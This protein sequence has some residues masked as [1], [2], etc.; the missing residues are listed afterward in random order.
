MFIW[1]MISCLI[2]I[3]RNT[4]LL[5]THRHGFWELLHFN[6]NLFQGLQRDNIATLLSIKSYLTAIKNALLA[7]CLLVSSF[8][9]PLKLFFLSSWTRPN[10]NRLL[11]GGRFFSYVNH[12]N[13]SHQSIQLFELSLLSQHKIPLQNFFPL[14][15]LT[16]YVFTG[17]VLTNV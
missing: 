5:T 3:Y 11:R 6:P 16:Q 17:S 7:A 13:S 8:I 15:H 14:R 2:L 12:L 10:A 9:L 1:K 4:L